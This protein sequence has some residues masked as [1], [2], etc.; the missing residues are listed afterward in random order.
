MKDPFE[1]GIKAFFGV[2][3]GVGILILSISIINKINNTISNFL[4][5]I[6][7]ENTRKRWELRKYKKR[8]EDIKKQKRL[9]RY[10]N[11]RLDAV[12]DDARN[13]FR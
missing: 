5:H 9:D 11:L 6:E 3:V 12:K 2:A 4:N 10:R 7:L 1:I 13:E 8:L